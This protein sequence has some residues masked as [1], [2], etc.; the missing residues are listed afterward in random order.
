MLTINY[1]EGRAIWP[2]NP[3]DALIEKPV[4]YDANDNGNESG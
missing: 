2:N 4:G 1:T 3:F